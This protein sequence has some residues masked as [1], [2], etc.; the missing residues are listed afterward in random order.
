[1]NRGIVFFLFF[2]LVFGLGTAWADGGGANCSI[3]PFVRQGAPPNVLLDISVETPMQGAAHPD[4]ECTGDPATD[5]Y[6]CNPDPSCRGTVS[7]CGHVSDCYDNAVEYYGYFDPDK[8]YTYVGSGSTGRFEPSS[9]T[10]NHQ[11]SGA[12][13]GNFLNWATM[14]AIDA[15]R[16]AFTGGNR[17]TLDGSPE[18]PGVTYLLRANQLRSEGDSWFPIKMIDGDVSGNY[19]PFSPGSD[20]D[21][22]IINKYKGFAVTTDC[23]ATVRATNGFPDDT[24]DIDEAD[25]LGL[26]TARVQVCDPSAGLESNCRAY[27]DGGT[28][29]YK[30]VGVMQRYADTM[31]F[32]LITYALGPDDS[33]NPSN[34]A[35]T[36]GGVIRANM[37]WICPTIP[38]GL[39]YHDGGNLETCDTPG[40]CANPESE[41]NADGTFVE[42][43]DNAPGGKSGVINYLN[44]FGYQQGYKSHDPISEMYYEA[45]R[46]YKN[47]GPTA[48]YTQYDDGTDIPATDDGF[49][50]Y[51][52]RS[53]L[54]WRDPMIYRCQQNFIV[55]LNDA[56]PWYDK[57]LPGT[58]FTSDTYDADGYDSEDDFHPGGLYVDHGEPTT[59]DPAIDVEDLTK[60]V[61]DME[62]ITNTERCI[63][64]V[65]GGTC[66][67]NNTSKLITNLGQ[68]H[69]TC[70]GASRKN[71][72]YI[73]GLAYYAHVNDLRADLDGMQNITT[74]VIDSQETNSQM[75]VGQ[76]NMLYL[77]AKYGGFNDRNNNGEPDERSEWDKDSS[78][79]PGYGFPDTYFFASDPSKVESALEQTFGEI[80]QRTS[81]GTAVSVLSTSAEGEGSLFQAFF[82]PAVYEG[83]EKRTW[84]GYLNAM[85]VDQY[86]NLREN[87]VVDTNPALVLDE[88]YVIEF[89]LS[90]TGE[91]VVHRYHDADGNGLVD[92]G[93]DFVDTIN[94]SELTPV[95]DYAKLLAGGG[96]DPNDRTI[97]TFKD[98]DWDRTPIGDTDEW[99]EFTAANAAA[100]QD[101][102]NAADE[103][104]AEFIIN[105]IRGAPLSVTGTSCRD[106]TID[107]DIWKL[108]D[109]V[110]S[111]P[112]VVG[113]PMGQY[114][115]IYGDTSYLPFIQKY[116]D[117][118]T[119]VYVGANDGMLHAFSA[120]TYHEGDD[121]NTVGKTERG[122]YEGSDRGTEKWAY[123]PYN[124][125]PHLKWLTD[126]D[127]C[128][129]YYADLKTR[130][131][132]ARIFDADTD[133]PNGWGTVLIGAMRLGGRDI[134]V[135]WP[136][137][138]DPRWFRSAYFALDITNP[139]S[140]DYP[141]LLWEYTSYFDNL[142]YTTSYPTTIRRGPADEA[143]TWYVIFASGP[144]T[145]D[146]GGATWG[147]VY[148]RN[149]RTG[150]LEKRFDI[151]ISN[152]PL[153]M[154]TPI[155]I[156]LGLDYNV[157]VAYI[158]ATYDDS[159]TWKGKMFRID[160][161][162]ESSTY[163]NHS[164][165]FSAEKPITSAPTA[166]L[167]P[168]NRLWLFWGSGRYFSD[169]DKTD[170]TPQRIYGVWD[171]GTGT[172]DKDNL[173]D[174]TLVKV[175]E[176][177]YV[178]LDGDGAYSGDDK[179]F[180]QY[181]SDVR[182]D[183]NSTPP[184]KYGWYLDMPATGERSLAKST[185][186][187]DIVLFPTFD[188]ND[189]LCDYGGDSYLYSLYYETGTAY[190]ESVMG[191]GSN[192]LDV[193]GPKQ[194]ILKKKY[195]GL[196]MPTSVVIHAGQQQGVTGMIQLGTGV[197]EEVDIIPATSPQSKVLFWREKT[198]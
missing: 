107:G 183:Y 9:I 44:Q 20:E 109:I 155:T 126:R 108:G 181:L 55:A 6:G 182:S 18:A 64:C 100:L 93:T 37:K 176:G 185:L 150:V 47:L 196:G 160:L 177:G 144:S 59:P 158:G 13:S 145:F 58:F 79:E 68:V 195:L 67:F 84:L 180:I 49:P 48:L 128:H 132:D 42:N 69:G 184:A 164:A 28:T 169:A 140:G 178:D 81:S 172:L 87:T 41:I 35:A 2:S 31:R 62:G 75:L 27:V 14:T 116:K 166:A 50:V 17:D 157:D 36:N 52:N 139:A 19:T 162:H 43:P 154:A 123:I 168:F 11:C 104:E 99:V 56:N 53:G 60:E 1:M 163:W 82:N 85:W 45:I 86:G 71:S 111:T 189:D 80:L 113:R 24:D 97:Y 131:V 141:K 22:Y 4:I 174:V 124:L 91:T 186:L 191:L 103:N 198:E 40:G 118:E 54:N 161:D 136:S 153:F 63:G 171:P 10:A 159:G 8:C 138:P 135:S 148:I 12:W 77:A 125:L 101:Y 96:W 149:L 78:G 194:E 34:R 32:G 143:G 72:Y 92:T 129:V 33:T 156:D 179:P 3:P 119:I 15:V 147:Y 137:P 175:H 105:Y 30:P 46:Y 120:G 73:A 83:S 88:D 115:L 142:S 188:P 21:V 65:P 66:D 187:G 90:P 23:S 110:N 122:W 5:S 127:Y 74:Y 57:R 167:D 152:K 89:D 95:Y 133:H 70:Y 151:N 25:E 102:L 165:F 51:A 173:N 190:M 170:D 192:T 94:L 117:R 26:Y 61:G 106:R 76:M 29:Y 114:H 197:V 134:G 98:I 16:K 146:G 130:V 193:G 112:S 121:L 39:Q 38:R 7:G